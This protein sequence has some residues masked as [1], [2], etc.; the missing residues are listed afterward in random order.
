M[1][2]AMFRNENFIDL[3]CMMCGKRWHVPKRNPLARLLMSDA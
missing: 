1:F 3:S 2:D